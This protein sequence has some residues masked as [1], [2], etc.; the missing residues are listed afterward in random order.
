MEGFCAVSPLNKELQ[1]TSDCWEVRNWPHPG[2][3]HAELSVLKQTTA[4]SASGNS[5]YL[6]AHITNTMQE[7][8]AVRLS[9]VW[10]GYWEW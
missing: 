9:G 2:M 7:K 5:E 6:F 8:E 4:D 1:A 3:S 10:E